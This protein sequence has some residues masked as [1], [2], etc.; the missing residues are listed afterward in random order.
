MPAVRRKPAMVVGQIWTGRTKICQPITRRK[1]VEIT[2]THVNW[3]M[4]G[5]C[6]KGPTTG[7]TTIGSWRSWAISL[8]QR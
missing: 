4:V 7:A 3:E 5:T 2:D 6:F 8:V 1:I